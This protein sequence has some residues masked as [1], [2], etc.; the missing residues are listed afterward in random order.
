MGY[1]IIETQFQE[2]YA[3]ADQHPRW[4]CK[5]GYRYAISVNDQLDSSKHLA[6]LLPLL[7]QQSDY[8]IESVVSTEYSDDWD[9]EAYPADFDLWLDYRPNGERDYNDKRIQEYLAQ[10]I[11]PSFGTMEK[12]W[13]KYWLGFNGERLDEKIWFTDSNGVEFDL[14]G[15]PITEETA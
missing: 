1:L 2:N 4:K 6:K 13:V 9:F 7:T 10:G 14:R 3:D 12:K 5:G 15:N 8:W 11:T